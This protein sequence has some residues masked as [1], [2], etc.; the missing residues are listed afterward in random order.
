MSCGNKGKDCVVQLTVVANFL[1]SK[2]DRCG[3]VAR[4]PR[5]WSKSAFYQR[6]F[7]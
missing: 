2:C 5:T 4:L 6:V 7:K 3:T 1:L